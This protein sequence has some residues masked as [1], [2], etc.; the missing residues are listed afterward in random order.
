MT[1]EQLSECLESFLAE[2]RDAR[3]LEAG[4]ELFDFSH[5]RYSVQTEFGKCLL[6]IWSAERNIVRRVTELEA[7]TGR[8]R[9]QV[10]RLGQAKPSWLEIVAGGD[11]QAPEARR[12]ARAA[13]LRQ[14]GRV[15][16]REF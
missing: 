8:L 14:L 15:L 5:A 4:E 1:A 12:E 11:A 13:Y 10:Q 2:N 7:K 16:Q 3:V 6:H 9:L